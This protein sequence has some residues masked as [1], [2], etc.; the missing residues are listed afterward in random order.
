MQTQLL[1]TYQGQN[2]PLWALSRIQH[3]SYKWKSIWKV[4]LKHEENASV[5]INPKALPQNIC[6]FVALRIKEIFIIP[7]GQAVSQQAVIEQKLIYTYTTYR[8]AVD[9]KYTNKNSWWVIQTDKSSRNRWVLEP[10]SSVS[11]HHIYAAGREQ[12]EVFILGTARISRAKRAQGSDP[13]QDTEV[14]QSHA[15]DLTIHF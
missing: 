4:L 15:C 11:Q 8:G 3:K 10:I 6:L 7:K 2:K 5:L 1:F 9:N 13:A 14:V 12:H